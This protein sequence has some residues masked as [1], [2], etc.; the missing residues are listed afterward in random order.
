[1]SQLACL[2][3]KKNKTKQKNNAAV[4]TIN[5]ILGNDGFCSSWGFA[6]TKMQLFSLVSFAFFPFPFYHFFIF[7]CFGRFG[8]MPKGGNDFF[9]N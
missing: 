9:L 2:T 8:K 4:V 6:Y 7:I 1:M 3:Q 5:D